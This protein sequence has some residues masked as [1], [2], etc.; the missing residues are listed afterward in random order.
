MNSAPA[1]AAHKRHRCAVL[2]R[3]IA[4]AAAL[5]LLSGGLVIVAATERSDADIAGAIIG[6]WEVR[7]PASRARF[8]KAYETYGRD[9][10][11]RGTL[12]VQN[13]FGAEERIEVGGRWSVDKG[14]VV[15]AITTATV[16]GF[17]KEVATEDFVSASDNSFV[18]RARSGALETRQRSRIPPTLPPLVQ[19]RPKLFTY[20]EAARVLR[21]VVRPEYSPEAR[22]LRLQG[23]GLFEL[24]FDYD[25]G[26]LKGIHIV[27]ST[28]SK[29]LDKDAIN[30][31][32][33]WRAKPR[34]IRV[35]RVPVKFRVS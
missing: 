28:G 7:V 3:V 5:C 25:T 31:L 10:S 12:I 29:R 27:Q 6:T 18:L 19:R 20:E 11:F 35:M 15:T 32:K 33:D 14:R 21:Y 22:S 9:G 30:A 17:S 4:A 26:R 16:P 8:K 34:A 13:D 23:E 24:R 1:V 2:A